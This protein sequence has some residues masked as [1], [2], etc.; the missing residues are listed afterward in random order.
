M[1]NF[2]TELCTLTEKIMIK[3]ENESGIEGQRRKS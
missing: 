1:E 2:P 3:L